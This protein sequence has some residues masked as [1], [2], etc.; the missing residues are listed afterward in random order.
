[1]GEC[2][3]SAQPGDQAALCPPGFRDEIRQILKYTTYRAISENDDVTGQKD[4]SSSII[5]D[6]SASKSRSSSS[7]SGSLTVR[8]CGNTTEIQKIQQVITFQIQK[9]M[10]N[11]LTEFGLMEHAMYLQIESPGH[12]FFYFW[13]D[14]VIDVRLQFVSF[15]LKKIFK[16]W[17]ALL[18]ELEQK[19][20]STKQ[21]ILCVTQMHNEVTH[22]VLQLESE[23]S[24][25]RRSQLDD[26]FYRCTCSIA[27]LTHSPDMVSEISISPFEEIKF[28]MRDIFW[29]MVLIHES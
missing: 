15:F 17:K 26:L 4:C 27:R 10:D 25:V 3:L 22:W 28:Q 20:W 2:V 7:G 6:A 11:I 14:A 9:A 8:S 13:H 1:M 19:G 29:A 12:P 5:L 16:T 23:S 18:Q 24:I 21:D